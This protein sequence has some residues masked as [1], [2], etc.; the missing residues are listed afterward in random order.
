M[1]RP[2][3]PRLTAAPKI[4]LAL[5]KRLIWATIWVSLLSLKAAQARPLVP[6]NLARYL[7]SQPARSTTIPLWAKTSDGSSAGQVAG[8]V[9]SSPSVPSGQSVSPSQTAPANQISHGSS[10]NQTADSAGYGQSTGAA[11]SSQVAGGVTP[12][13]V[14]GGVTPSQV[15]GGATP[16]QVVH[17]GSTGQVI[18]T[19]STSQIS[20]T[21]PVGQTT[22]GITSSQSGGFIVWSHR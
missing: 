3:R 13:Q 1:I 16:S 6:H 18:D 10:P 21:T 11:A 17:N 7:A 14:A 2:C 15:A 20:G 19:S 12:S 9:P 5:V 8:S 4:T 22:D